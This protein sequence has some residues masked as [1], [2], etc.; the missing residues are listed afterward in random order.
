MK[1]QVKLLCFL[2]EKVRMKCS[3]YGYYIVM[4]VLKDLNGICIEFEV[5]CSF[6]NFWLIYEGFLKLQDASGKY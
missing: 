1:P 6:G 5:D 4:L 2:L 3:C